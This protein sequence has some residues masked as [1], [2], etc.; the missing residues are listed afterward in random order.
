MKKY[1]IVKN[2]FIGGCIGFTLMNLSYYIV[3]FIMKNI[4]QTLLNSIRDFFIIFFFGGII[5]ILAVISIRSLKYKDMKFKNKQK[6]PYRPDKT[7]FCLQFIF[8][9]RRRRR[10]CN[11]KYAW[12][13]FINELYIGFCIM[14]IWLPFRIYII[15]K[16]YGYDKKERVIKWEI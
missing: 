16:E 4:N 11:T 12:N 5:Y 15:K 8:W 9:W 6:V 10:W 14:G 13:Y 3:N 1:D 2:F 7:L